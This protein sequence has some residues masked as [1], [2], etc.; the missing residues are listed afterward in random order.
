LDRSGWERKKDEL[1]REEAMGGVKIEEESRKEPEDE[2][3][4]S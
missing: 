4:S 2:E 3:E 1:P